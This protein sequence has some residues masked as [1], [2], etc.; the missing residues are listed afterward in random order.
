MGLQKLRTLNWPSTCTTT[1][2]QPRPMWDPM[3]GQRLRSCGAREAPLPLTSGGGPHDA[4]NASL[5]DVGPGTVSAAVTALD[6]TS[7]YI[8]C[9]R[10]LLPCSYGVVLWQILTGGDPV[11]D[12]RRYVRGGNRCPPAVADLLMQCLD[13]NPAARPSAGA[14]LL[15]PYAMATCVSVAATSGFSVFHGLDLTTYTR[16][17]AEWVVDGNCRRGGCAA[18]PS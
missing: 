1:T 17:P 16:A 6:A 3:C 11:T 7:A 2:W 5:Q 8:T 18:Q 12:R 10:W 14:L 13:R 15:F 4:C 9:E